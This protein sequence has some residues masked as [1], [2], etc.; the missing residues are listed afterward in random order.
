M[1]NRYEKFVF[2]D[3]RGITFEVNA[4][5]GK[6]LIASDGKNGELIIKSIGVN[7]YSE[8]F[9]KPPVPNG[10][11]HIEGE[12]NT[13]FVIERTVDGSQFVWIPVGSLESNG[14]LDG[15]N[16]VEK[17]GRR[18]YQNEEFSSQEFN[19]PLE[20]E[21]IEQLESVKKYGGFYISRY[22]IS[23]SKG[24]P[25]SVKRETPWV[26]I[27]FEVAMEVAA[28]FENN[29]TV[30]SHLPFGAEYDCVLEWFIKTK[31]KSFEDIAIDS[32]NWGNYW[33]TKNSPRKLTITGFRKQ[34]CV[35]NIYD[36]A[37][38]IDEWTQEYN[39]NSYR[40]MRGGKYQNYGSDFQVAY[41]SCAAAWDFYKSTGF[42][43]ALCIK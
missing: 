14:T 20:G 29:E 3:E 19:E 26:D 4:T 40:I 5:E 11:K 33:N 25:Q 6:Q 7:S 2:K 42:R 34:W 12:W 35:N 23:S 16:F 22:N 43:V 24:K 10:Y 18:N 38:N 13:G 27:D 39:E 32:S 30:K 1:K 15:E 41:R 21:L 36:F 17:F 37:G 28:S 8:D 9:V 31:S